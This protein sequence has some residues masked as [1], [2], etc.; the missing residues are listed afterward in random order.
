MDYS[1]T[2]VK[3]YLL[4]YSVVKEIRR[5]MLSNKDIES[6]QTVQIKFEEIFPQIK[7]TKYNIYWKGKF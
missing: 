6:F 3:L 2:Q 7:G 4:Q 1:Q 5:V